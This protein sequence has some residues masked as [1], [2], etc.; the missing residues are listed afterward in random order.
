MVSYGLIKCGIFPTR[1]G[2]LVIPLHLYMLL[3][4]FFICV[5][6]C[7]NVYVC[8]HIVW[9]LSCDTKIKHA[10]YMKCLCCFV[11]LFAECLAGF[12][13]DGCNQ[14]CSCVNGGSCDPVHGRCTCPPGFHGNYCEQ[15]RAMHAKCHF[16][17]TCWKSL[18]ILVEIKGFSLLLCWT[19]ACMFCHMCW[20]ATWFPSIFI[21]AVEG[22]H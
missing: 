9:L 2:L 19:I 21:Y 20:T 12:Y 10:P 16:T 3:F 5:I 6:F 13:G 4:F 1:V 11:F 7:L 8:S 22:N 15:G 14:T 17:Q 18:G